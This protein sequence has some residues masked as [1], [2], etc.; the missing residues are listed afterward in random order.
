[1]IVG[2]VVYLY[3]TGLIKNFLQKTLCEA[4]AWES[5]PKLLKKRK[6]ENGVHFT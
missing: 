2:L 5:I 6:R 3:T 4:G 1:M